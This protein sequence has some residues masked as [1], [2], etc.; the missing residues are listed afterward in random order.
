MPIKFIVIVFLSFCVSTKSLCQLRTPA[1]VLDSL[2]INLP[3]PNK[4]IANYVSVVQ[5]GKLL[6]L[7]GAIPRGEQEEKFKGKLGGNISI[8]TGYLGAQT[9]A[10][11]HLAIL[12]AYLGDLS[13]IKR[14]VKVLGMV[15]A[16]PDFEQHP[17]VING[18]SDF[19]VLI[20]GEKGKHARSAVGV[21]SLPFNFCV[22]VEAIFEIE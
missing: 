7:S 22:E 14:V 10:I 13:K 16:S 15:N 20:F 5:A 1:S 19:M 18:Y 6:F 4:A 11:Q 21:S 3:E 12:K 9:V 17:K 8:E 2:H